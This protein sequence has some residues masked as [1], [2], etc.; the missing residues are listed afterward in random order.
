MRQDALTILSLHSHPDDFRYLLAPVCP[1]RSS[2]TPPACSW[3]PGNNY[4]EEK[5]SHL[6]LQP[7]L[8]TVSSLRIQL[9]DDG[10]DQR[11]KRGRCATPLLSF[12]VSPLTGA[13]SP[14][15]SLEFG[16]SNSL[17]GKSISMKFL[18]SHA[19]LSLLLC[20]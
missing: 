8:L 9:R 5:E 7:L 13:S 19:I 20:K 10:A 4:Y 11:K 1:S 15:F 6:R 12:F 17:A 16:V 2:E 18:P 14:L 3:E